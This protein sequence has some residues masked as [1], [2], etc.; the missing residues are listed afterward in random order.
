MDAISRIAQMLEDEST[1]KRMAAAVVLGELKPKDAAAVAAL[2]KA[3]T[4]SSEG[5]AA[6]ALSALG[7]IGSMKALPVVLDSLARAGDVQ[8]EAARALSALG[9]E[10]LPA[11]RDH[12]KDATP[13]VRAAV[14][15]AI[16]VG[17]SRQ[18]F[19]IALEGLRG[20]SWEAANRVTL[21]LRPEVKGLSPADRKS[22]LKQLEKFV[23]MKR[24]QEDETALRAALKVLGFLELTDASDTLLAHLSSRQGP[25]VRIEA[26]TA[27]RFAL[28]EGPSRKALRRLMELLA[29]EEQLVARAA[30][31]TLTV[32]PLADELAEDLAE[33][34]V[35]EDSEVAF[36]AITRL[37]GMGGKVA[38]KALVPVAAGKDRAR[39]QAAAKALSALEDGPRLLAQALTDADEEVGAQV[40]AEALQPVARRLGKK[41]I[42]ALLK[43]GTKDLK[44][45]VAVARR[46]LEPVREVDPEAWATTLR[47]AAGASTKK[48]ASRAEVLYG[49]LSRSPLGTADDRYAYARLL[50]SRSSK[51]PHPKARQRDPGLLELQKLATEGYPLAQTLQKDKTLDDEERYYLGFHFAESHVPEEQAVG[52]DLLEAIAQS[53]KGKLKKAAK[54]KLALL[55]T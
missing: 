47:D 28:A 7:A 40:L 48:D 46:K 51:D 25:A 18:S 14:A 30:R 16:Q 20:Q 27:L 43:A 44:G 11:V 15:G 10:A 1:H 38:Q 21:A 32:L 9:E 55:E 3:A 22:L 52:Y 39:A 5:L 12:L 13:E 34:A 4:D 33:C 54:N 2:C 35:S 53:G 6:A 41:E 37:G 26:A 49:L 45:A 19:E 42:A 29:D 8:K 36:W 24:V 50:L 17:G 31:D 23:S